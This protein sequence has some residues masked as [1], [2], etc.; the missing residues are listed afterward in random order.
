MKPPMIRTL[1]A[2]SMVLMLGALGGPGRAEPPTLGEYASAVDRALT[3]PDGERVV[4]GFISRQLQLPAE[5][6]RL[7]RLQ[8]GLSLGN[9]L[10]ANRVAQLAKAPVEQI[11]TEFKGGRSW[12]DIARAREV[13]VDRLR[14]EMKYS[15]ETVEQRLE[16]KAPRPYR[17]DEPVTRQP[18]PTVPGTGPQI[19]T[20]PRRY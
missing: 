3:A 17:A 9:L 4:L 1:A 11:V 13:N 20:P 5:T 7:Q 15:Q 10:V 19:P 18:A 8:T 14:D 16:D 2:I 6:L 12:D